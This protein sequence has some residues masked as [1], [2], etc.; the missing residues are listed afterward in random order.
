MKILSL[1][2]VGLGAVFPSGDF[3]GINE[4]YV[5]KVGEKI[6]DGRGKELDITV[7]DITDSFVF[8]HG[9]TSSDKYRDYYKVETSD[10]HIRFLPKDKYIAE[11]GEY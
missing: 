6:K 1:Q 10:G 9:S 2:S 5:V 4:P 7:T 11:W 3:Q 8:I